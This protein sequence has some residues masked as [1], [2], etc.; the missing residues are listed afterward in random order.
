MN[1]NPNPMEEQWSEECLRTQERLGGTNIDFLEFVEGNPDSLKRSSFKALEL[2]NKLFTLQPW[3]TFLGRKTKKLF[4][5]AGIK[6]FDLI[7]RIPQRFF[8]YDPYEMSKYFE[9]PVNAVKPQ[10]EGLTA[11]HLDNL[12]SRGD[13]IFTPSGL[14]CLEYNFS[15]HLGGLESPRWEALYLNTPIVSQFIKDYRVKIENRNLISALLG[16]MI[17]LPLERL[18]ANH[19][20]EINIAVVADHF[21]DTD[22]EIPIQVYLNKIYREVLSQSGHGLTGRVLICDYQHLKVSGGYVFFKEKKIHALLEFYHGVVHPR[23][24]AVFKAGNISIFNGPITNIMTNKLTLA[25][26]SDYET[27]G[28]FSAAEKRTIDRYI[29]WTRKL[30]RGPFTYKGEKTADLEDFVLTHQE[31]MVIKPAD[32]LGGAGVLV[33][34]RCPVNVWEEQVKIA[35]QKRNWLVQELL[36]SPPALYQW[37]EKGCE[38][39]DTV[40]GLFIFGSQYCGAWARVMPQRRNKG[41]V[42]CHQGATVSVVFEVND[43]ESEGRKKNSPGRRNHDGPGNNKNIESRL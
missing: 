30:C 23:V 14:K 33:G 17:R 15:A 43:A 25:L 27:T 31:T 18:S 22:K 37:G 38:P 2:N 39:H 7:K 10:L 19:P 21:V 41:I 1:D 35:L 24:L 16:H 4:M 12:L 32:G 20:R 34:P 5:D 3:P 36:A 8:N 13:F 9:I 28:G 26:L 29:P 40:W 42:N 6:L 11:S